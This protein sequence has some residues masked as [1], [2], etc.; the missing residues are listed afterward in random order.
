[1]IF[2]LLEKSRHFYGIG[3]FHLGILVTGLERLSTSTGFGVTK[4]PKPLHGD[5]DSIPPNC[6]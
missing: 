3:N 2:G 5:P 4:T 1:L 6:V